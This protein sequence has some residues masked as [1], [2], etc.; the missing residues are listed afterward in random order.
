[1][2]QG[3]TS[4]LLSGGSGERSGVSG[5]KQLALVAGWPV[6]SWSARALDQ[7]GFDRL[8]VVCHPDRV[9]EYRAQAIEP[10][11]LDTP[12]AFAAGG[13][14][15]QASVASGLAA[16]LDDSEIVV[17][18][19]GARP[20]VS[21]GT[22]LRAVELLRSR[23]DAAGVVIGHPVVDTLKIVDGTTVVETPD[24]TRYWAAQTPQIF[25][26]AALREAHR[27]AQADG[28][29]GTDDA[30]AV[31]HAGGT[32]LMVEGDRDNIKVTLPEDFA[33][34]AAMLERR[35]RGEQ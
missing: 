12:V 19:D 24:R 13:A 17:I 27:V 2:A 6:M 16:M 10:L 25:Y 23:P 30:A 18:H 15:R 32:V 35:D 11:G 33:F 14:T 28:Y 5:G 9:D 22:V 8:I 7:C 31:E 26:T 4:I 34:V 29:V 1:M 20:L 21:A 3:V